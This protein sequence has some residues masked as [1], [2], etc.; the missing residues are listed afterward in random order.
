MIVTLVEHKSRYLVARKQNEQ[1]LTLREALVQ[2]FNHR[3]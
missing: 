3:G 1:S 2:N